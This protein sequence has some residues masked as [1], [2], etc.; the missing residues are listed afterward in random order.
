[1]NHGE[2]AAF[3]YL[4]LNGFF[5][6]ANFVVHASGSVRHTTDSDVLAVRPPFVYEEI[7][8]QPDDWDAFLVE[9]LEFSR[10]VGLVCEVK[11]GR[12]EAQAVFPEDA[13]RY[14]IARL[15]MVPHDQVDQ[16]LHALSVQPA[17][18]IGDDAQIAKL[19]VARNPANGPFL[20]R[21]L[22][23]VE[24]FLFDRVARYPKEKHRDR[25]FFGPVLFQTIIELTDNR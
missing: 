13:V 9:R 6:I 4:R 7:G 23:D 24:Q 21:S 25:M 11:T 1:M 15:G 10:Q 8:G 20:S 17:V 16:V 18:R 2:E 3:W 14:S 22:T 19:L 5:P 12:Y